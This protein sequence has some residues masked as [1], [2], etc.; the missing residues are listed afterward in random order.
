MTGRSARGGS[1]DE[2]ATIVQVAGLTDVSAIDVGYNAVC[3]IDGGTAHCWGLN[4][5]G[6]LGDGTTENRG[7]PTQVG[8]IGSATSVSAG[9]GQACAV[10]DGTGYCWGYNGFGQLGDAA[11]E[12]RTTAVRVTDLSGLRAIGAGEDTT[13]AVSGGRC[14]A[15]ANWRADA[16]VRAV[17]GAVPR[18]AARTVANYLVRV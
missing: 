3:A 12:D 6:Q 7:T 16:S 10:S 17:V 13:C 18:V 15:G 11:P 9:V 4:E 5:S 8:D 14:T 1:T 2:R